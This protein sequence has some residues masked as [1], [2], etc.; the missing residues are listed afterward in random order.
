M[1]TA[2]AG[3]DA[4]AATRAL[5][6]VA[7]LLALGGIAAAI[8]LDPTFSWTTDALSDLGVRDRS[9]PAFNWGL[10]LG[11]AAGV[12]YALGLRCSSSEAGITDG[13]RAG[14]LA[15]AMVAMA[16]V[17]VFDLTEPLHGPAAIG[18]YALITVVFA[19]D[20]L[21]R[22]GT[23]TGRLALAFA[24]VHVAVWA[25]FA[26]GWWPVSGLALPELPGAFMLAAWVWVVGP[27]PV[28]SPGLGSSGSRRGDAGT[29][30]H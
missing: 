25:T 3:G 26:A 9:A 15:L 14:V 1:F 13:A 11:G 30:E 19:I 27:L 16:G 2:D 5:G 12:G 4:V 8:L 10:I 28:L 17:G 24:P 6:A 29:D 18:F 22:R 7:T 20:G 23:A 21:A